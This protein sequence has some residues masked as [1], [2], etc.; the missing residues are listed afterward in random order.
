VAKISRVEFLRQESFAM[1]TA[2][3]YYHVAMATP[4]KKS[5]GLAHARSANSQPHCFV[6]RHLPP[7]VTAFHAYAFAVSRDT[8]I[9]YSSARRDGWEFGVGKNRVIRWMHM[10][11]H[12]GWLVRIDAGKRRKRNPLTGS[13]EPI[14]YRVVD[15]DSWAKTHGGKCRFPPVPTVGTGITPPVSELKFTSTHNGD[16]PVPTVDFTCPQIDVVPV[17]TVGTK[18]VL[19]NN[20]EKEKPKHIPPAAELDGFVLPDWINADLWKE[21]EQMRRSIRKPLTTAK[22]CSYTVKALAKLRS[23]GEDVTQVL[24]QSIARSYSGV[25]PVTAANRK[26]TGKA[27]TLHNLRATGLIGNPRA[28]PPEPGKYDGVD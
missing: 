20:R 17:P 15:H 1:T 25:F 8:G 14:R 6:R 12:T 19:S 7:D 21:F 18:N 23:D 5:A 9:F 16:R 28:L 24:E 10:L 4:L 26:L 11:E 2:A 22:A 13:M 3:N 27:L